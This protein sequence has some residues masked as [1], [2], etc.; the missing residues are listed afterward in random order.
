MD[1]YAAMFHV[2][3]CDS[4]TAAA[5]AAT[6]RSRRYLRCNYLKLH[7]SWLASVLYRVHRKMSHLTNIATRQANT[8]IKDAVFAAFVA[9]G[10]IVSITTIST[11][12]HAASTHVVGR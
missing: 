2:E 10:A 3:R 4:V 9:L 1:S 5:P 11:V 7:A 8:R 6:G 12:A